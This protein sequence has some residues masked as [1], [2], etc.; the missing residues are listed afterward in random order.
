M[1]IS[2]CFLWWRTLNRIY[3]GYTSQ[4]IRLTTDPVGLY[5]R[6][7][8]QRT[9]ELWVYRTSYSRN[10]R[11]VGLAWG[12][13]TIVFC[14]L[15]MV[16]FSQ[17]RWIANYDRD[18]SATTGYFGV[19]KRCSRLS[20]VENGDGTHDDDDYTC[21]GEVSDWDTILNGWFKATAALHGAG[22]ILILLCICCLLL[23][24]L[25]EASLAYT[26]CGSIQFLAG[27][28]PTEASGQSP[29]FQYPRPQ[30]TLKKKKKKRRAVKVWKTLVY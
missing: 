12:F 11:A 22:I 8:S 28:S 21:V 25:M 30:H 20:Y 3:S 16:A 4:C 15:S 7:M 13:C 29:Q 24:F 6:M 18:T 1:P 26:L 23:F 5:P 2:G 19:Y 14:V 10:A 9:E 27:G 17:P